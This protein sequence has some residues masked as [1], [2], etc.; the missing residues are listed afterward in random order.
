MEIH[1]ME[2]DLFCIHCEEEVPHK[3]IYIN[4]R[5][6]RIE[7]EVCHRVVELSLDIKREAMKEL[8]ER[9][10]TKPAR[11]T[12]EY[13]EDLS[14]FLVTFPLRVVSKPFRLLKEIHDTRKIIKNYKN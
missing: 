6:S 1:E 8:Y 2:A 3:L 7:C 11:I 10:S 13:K 9:I 12:H 5:L 4:D 14:H